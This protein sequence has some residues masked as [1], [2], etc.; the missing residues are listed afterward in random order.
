VECLDDDAV[1]AFVDGRLSGPD[2]AAA[3]HHLANCLSCSDLIAAAAGGDPARLAMSQ[4]ERG[5]AR[6]AGLARGATVGRYVI[7]DVVGRG[8]MGEVYA[9]YDPQLDRKVALKLLHDQP[10]AAGGGAARAA[11]ERLLREAKVIARLSH[12]NVVVVHDAGEIDERVFLAMEFVEGQTLGAWLAA[13]PR[14]WRAIREV[15]LAAGE[16]LAAAHEAGLVHRDFKPQNVMVARDGSV[17]VMDFGLARDTGAGGE[18]PA[19]EAAREAGAAPGDALGEAGALTR[20]GTL[21]GTPLY[22]APEQFLARAT[23]ARTDQFSFAVALYEALYGERPF[24]GDSFAAL[25]EQVVAGRIREPASRTR[26]PAFLRRL[27]LRGLR[28]DPAARYQSMRELLSALRHDP[29]RRRRGLAVAAAVAALAIAFAGG[30]HRFATR[31]QRL[32]RAAGERLADAWEPAGTAGGGARRAEIQRAFAATRASF[33]ADT[34]TRVSALLDGYAG[35]WSR[36]YTDACEAT[37][38]RGDQSSEVLDL[39]MACLEGP[40]SALHALTD[41]FTHADAAVVLQAVNAAQALPPLDRCADLA[42]LRAT[43]SPP[44][45]AVTRA[46]VADLRA[47]L[48]EVKALTDTG[49]LALA[50]R[51]VAPVVEAA[52]TTRYAPLLAETLEARSWLEAMLGDPAAGVKS[53]EEALRAALAGRRDDIALECAALLVGYLSDRLQ[54]L[55]DAE[56]WDGLGRALLE[57]LGPGHERSAAWLANDRGILRARRGDKAGA[58]ADVREGLAIKQRVLGP[59]HPDVGLSLAT[60]GSILEELGDAA[61]ALDAADRFLATYRGAYGADSPLLGHPLNNRGIALFLLGRH[62]EAQAALRDAIA[63]MS[64]VNGPDNGVVA[65]P[66]TALGRSL[67]ETENARDAVPLL[68][69]ALRIRERGEP[70]RHL[71]AETAFALARARWR[72]GQRGDDVRALAVVARDAY[73]APPGSTREAAEVDAWLAANPRS[74]SGLARR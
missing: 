42:A 71:V 26:A 66:L 7:L 60:L 44:A 69:R 29:A 65:H 70:N 17:R 18:A 74:A 72:A 21:L 48:A 31:G 23:D 32:C 55:D 62:A 27:L 46:R 35:R 53:A 63:R 57:R 15:F 49:Q 37:H 2:R 67:L 45:D 59:N 5:A 47:E 8:G 20:T 52:R 11:R 64:V 41:V 9:A 51:K 12:P 38:V 40:R 73:L 24:H 22:M 1:L 33:A 36:M 10:G 58:L 16:A 30:A 25:A 61:G 19:A 56:R 34:W 6:L 14:G 39:R 68:E 28:A 4:S 50:S 43:V 3:E 54:R 13:A